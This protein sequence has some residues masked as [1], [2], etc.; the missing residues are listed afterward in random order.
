MNETTARLQLSISFDEMIFWKQFNAHPGNGTHEI[1]FW[2]GKISKGFLCI[3]E[4]K[5]LLWDL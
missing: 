3:P 1:T 4:K 2:G 5:G